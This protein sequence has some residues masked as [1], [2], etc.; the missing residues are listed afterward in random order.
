[1]NLRQNLQN[2]TDSIPLEK[3]PEKIQDLVLITGHSIKIIDSFISIDKYT[4]VVHSFELVEDPLYVSVAGFGFG[5]IFAGADFI[6]FLLDQNFLCECQYDSVSKDDLIMYFQNELFKH[7]GLVLGEDR[8]LSKW[9]EGYLY[10]HLIWEVPISYGNKVRYF[11]KL[12]PGEGL[13]LF[14]SFAESKGLKFK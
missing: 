12:A 13:D 3:H 1:M 5:R 14:I 6:H 11:K 7:V 4:C 10:N 8:V 9:G 2:I